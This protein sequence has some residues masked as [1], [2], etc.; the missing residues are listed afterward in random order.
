[1]SKIVQKL[2]FFGCIGVVLVLQEI[3]LVSYWS[4]VDFR[5]QNDSRIGIG[6]GISAEIFSIVLVS[7]RIFRPNILDIGLVLV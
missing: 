6:I 7:S 5:P 2:Q 3:F 4:R 1:M